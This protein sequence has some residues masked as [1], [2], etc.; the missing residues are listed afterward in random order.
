MSFFLTAQA[1]GLKEVT[2][3]FSAAEA[4]AKQ[5]IRGKLKEAAKLVADEAKSQTHSRRVRSAITWDVEVR[6]AADYIARV[7]PTAKKAF[8]AHFLEFGTAHSRAFPFLAPAREA[9]EDEVV[10]LVG[11]SFEFLNRRSR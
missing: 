4:E 9:K 10:N 8:F 3:I 1:L 7:G 11:D 2:G 6:S 5:S